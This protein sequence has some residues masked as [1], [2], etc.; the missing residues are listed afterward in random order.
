M[1][2]F[3][4]R[5]RRSYS[6]AVGGFR[7]AYRSA[8][9]PS[10]SPMNIVLAGAL[11]GLARPMIASRL[12][13]FFNVGGVADSDNAILGVAG[14]F[15]SKQSNKLIKTMGLMAMGTEAGIVASNVINKN[16]TGS[17]NTPAYD[18]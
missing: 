9:R 6:R 2:R 15:A 4:K 18:Y 7:R 17:T 5:A 14:Y 11:Y 10:V 1:A 3:R 16:M 12:P 13:T 8:R